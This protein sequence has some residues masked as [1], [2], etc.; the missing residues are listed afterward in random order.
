MT[1]KNI[2]SM[3]WAVIITFH[4]VAIRRAGLAGVRDET[5]TL[6]AQILDTRLHQF[7]SH[8]NRENDRDQ[9][10]KATGEDV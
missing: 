5:Q 7:E 9:S 8:V 6:G 3:P 4:G 10:D 1:T 2:I